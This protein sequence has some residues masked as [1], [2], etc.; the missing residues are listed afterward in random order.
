MYRKGNAVKKICCVLFAALLCC[1]T[2]C[3]AATGGN[4]DAPG[5]PPTEA[6]AVYV[7]P[8]A[9]THDGYTLDRVV[10]LSRHNIRSPLTG[11]DWEAGKEPAV[12]G[13]LKTAS[14]LSDALLLSAPLVARNAANPLLKEIQSEMTNK[15]RK[16]TFLCGHDLNLGCLLDS[17]EV[18]PYELPLAIEKRTPIGSK[19]VF[20]R[21]R[22]EGGE[23]F[24]DVDLVYQTPAQLR[25][26]D[27]LTWEHS[28][29]IYDLSFRETEQNADGLYP[30][31]VLLDRFKSAVNAYD[32]MA[33]T[34]R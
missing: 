9:L 19:L 7:S 8:D 34:Y 24:W 23:A 1:S 21:W 20:S 6:E 11:E 5:Q 30:E 27:I 16:F 3:A 22:S 13:S 15:E 33:E 25:N 17:L 31:K 10:V 2:V 18:E 29:S 28:P 4:A 12:Q 14:E 32:S 26:A